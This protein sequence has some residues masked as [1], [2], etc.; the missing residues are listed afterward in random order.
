MMMRCEKKEGTEMEKNTLNWRQAAMISL[1]LL[2]AS[3]FAAVVHPA[4]AEMSIEVSVK[5]NF[6]VGESI[7]FNYTITSSEDLSTT[8]V[9]SVN[10]RAWNQPL[11]ELI[12][13]RLVRGQA[14]LGTYVY[15]TV[16]RDMPS[17]TCTAIVAV[18]SPN[19]EKVE[20]KDFGIS[21]AETVDFEINS[22]EDAEQKSSS[23][24][25]VKGA[26][27][28]LSYA[29]QVQQGGLQT[30]ATL[31]GPDKKEQKLAEFPASIR[32]EQ[33]GTYTLT[34]T[35]S[36]EGYNPATKSILF[37]VVPQQVSIHEEK[38]ACNKNLFCEPELN[39]SS[40]NCGDCV[41]VAAASEQPS[42]PGASL[43][44][45]V[46]AILIIAAILLF[47]IKSSR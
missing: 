21:T 39:E 11:L 18:D 29:A 17:Q 40:Q 6:T 10:C 13:I 30:T 19:G 5:D 27:I 3:F 43:F 8:H 35:A 24:I 33:T 14:Y 41:V 2:L 36:K 22:Y 23:R 42:L 15:G 31:E 9:P 4:C 16:T 20:K 1:V 26:T 25:F 46:I 47:S 45:A 7:A 32:P 44:L 38:T 28:Y 34:V 37:A 12:P